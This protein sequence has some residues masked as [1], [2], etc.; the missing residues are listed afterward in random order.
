[1]KTD[2]LLKLIQQKKAMRS[3][4]A[5][6]LPKAQQGIPNPMMPGTTFATGAI[7]RSASP[8]DLATGAAFTKLPSWIALA[9]RMMPEYNPHNAGRN[10]MF[11]NELYE[12]VKKGL[13]APTK[14][15]GGLAKAQ[16]GGKK[17]SLYNTL[18]DYKES[19]DEDKVEFFDVTGLT[20][21]DDAVK[22]Y[23]SWTTSNR[24]Y[25]TIPEGMDMFSAVPLFGRAKKVYEGLKYIHKPLRPAINKLYGLADYIR[26]TYDKSKEEK[27]T[28]G[29]AKA[30]TGLLKG[31]KTYQSDPEYFNSRAVLH[32]DPRYN[33]QVK[34]LIFSGK[35]AYNPATGELR[36]M[37]STPAPADVRQMSTREY[38]EGVRRDPTDPRFAGA[39]D[40]TKQIIQESTRQAY[41][42]PLMYAPGT[43]GMAM[44]PGGFQLGYGLSQGATQA[45]E[46]NYGNAA[47]T[48]GLSMLP[49]AGRIT[50]NYVI[51]TALQS[52]L[53][54]KVVAPQTLEN[55]VG[56]NISL[57][58]AAQYDPV[59][60]STGAFGEAAYLKKFPNIII[61]KSPSDRVFSVMGDAH[62]TNRFEDIPQKPGQLYPKYYKSQSRATFNND[63]YPYEF[64]VMSRVPG[65]PVGELSTKQ[66][67]SIPK[68]SWNSLLDELQFL[69]EKDVGFDMVG[70]NLLY[71]PKTA[72]FG[73]IDLSPGAS[74]TKSAWQTHV[75]GNVSPSD[76]PQEA[77]E[78]FKEALVGKLDDVFSRKDKQIKWRIAQN[79]S[80]NVLQAIK[81]FQ[82]MENSMQNKSMPNNLTVDY[83]PVRDM[84]NDRRYSLLNQLTGLKVGGLAKAQVGEQKDENLEKL[85]SEYKTIQSR[86]NE[87]YDDS[88]VKKLKEVADKL[89]QDRFVLEES[90]VVPENILNWKHPRTGDGPAFCIGTSCYIAN[91]AGDPFTFYS[92]TMA[93]DYAKDNPESTRY[94]EQ[95]EKYIEPGDILQFKSGSEQGWPYHAYTVLDIG[96]VDDKGYKPIK[97]VGSSGHGPVAYKD[98]YLGPDNKVYT[99]PQ[100]GLM[101]TQL[102]KRKTTSKS[103]YNDA[104]N[105][106]NELKKQIDDIDPRIFNPQKTVRYNTY[107]PTEYFPSDSAFFGGRLED[108]SYDVPQRPNIYALGPGPDGSQEQIYLKDSKLPEILRMASDKKYDIMKQHNISGDEYDAIV[109]NM[110]GMYGA[111]TKFGTDYWGKG[112][113]E[114]PLLTKTLPVFSSVGPFQL[115][116]NNFSK[117]LKKKYSKDDL[118]DPI[119]GAQANIEFLAENIPLLRK[120]AYDKPDDPTYTEFIT[121]DNYLEYIPYLQAAPGWLRGDKATKKSKKDV[122]RGEH[123]YKK[124]VDYYRSFFQS[125]PMNMQEVEITPEK[126]QGGKVHKVKIKKNK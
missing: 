78:K 67:S 63:N 107:L 99:S 105:R 43:I 115:G 91:Q 119:K 64:E 50:N 25:P 39:D 26:E 54:K 103:I 1:M 24:T 72:K 14:Q 20:S 44:L 82:L 84:L 66:L 74:K 65:K 118:Y 51:P 31:F 53:A 116:R 12:D 122:V 111:E 37:N 93:Q 7:E 81:N 89:V 29:L 42:N 27:Q 56:K 88:Y 61:K 55:L 112:V 33:E 71:D 34:E 96:D 13:K 19:P 18:L 120:R 3:G 36:F 69:R 98:Y 30:Q 40:R 68:E 109:S 38:T 23:D 73:M 60:I 86:I 32:D 104:V 57:S 58:N 35:A 16:P 48:A 21:W 5:L 102:L 9:A 45:G 123:D 77:R 59:T 8:I 47:L 126:R 15:I 94:L 10:I 17:N 46:G 100:G 95:S 121:P 125:F 101:P 11:A 70:A 106:R 2:K 124:L 108:V 52:S 76:T 92:N 62:L 97:V 28:G 110:L 75:L 113:P 41:E 22:G 83:T 114:W 117:E 49:V 80:K 85:I 79:K 4:G 87:G 90:G 6:P